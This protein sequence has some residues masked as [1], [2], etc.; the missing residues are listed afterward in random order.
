MRIDVLF[1]AAAREKAG[2]ERM[3][4]DLADGATVAHLWSRL[5]HDFPSLAP[6]LTS[7]RAAVDEQFAP[8]SAALRDGSTV[9]VLPPVS[10]G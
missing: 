6:I 3:S 1:F 5:A 10:G 7:S 2:T 4:I 8:M 9:A